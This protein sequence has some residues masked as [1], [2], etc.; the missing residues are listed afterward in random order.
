MP[1]RPIATADVLSEFTQA[2]Q[3]QLQNIQGT[4]SALAN[5]LADV[6][7]SYVGAMSAAGYAT[8]ASGNIPDQLR[9][10]VTAR[11]RWRWLN[12]FPTL[13]QMQTDGRK[14]ANEE[15]VE[16]LRLIQQR[17]FGAIED[18]AGTVSSAANWNS[19][20]KIILRTHPTPPASTQ[21]PP[22]TAP[23]YANPAGPADN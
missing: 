20:N 13:K 9:E 21:F 6:V 10:H 11:A 12:A 1:W 15:A 14:A 22:Q 19:E 18:P 17:K 23:P 4:T 3:A 8:I 2:E 5:I 16:A 7:K